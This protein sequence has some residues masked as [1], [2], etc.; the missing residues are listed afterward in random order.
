VEKDF[1]RYT[2]NSSK[3]MECPNP[4]ACLGGYKPN[5]KYPVQCS[6]GYEGIL[7]TKCQILDNVKY[8]PLSNF[9][10]SK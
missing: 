5:E 6:T 4:N 3:I 9:R 1:W 10:C 2:T 7:C 8:Q